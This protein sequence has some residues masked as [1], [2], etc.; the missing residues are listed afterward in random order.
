MSVMKKGARSKSIVNVYDAKTHLSEL[1]ERA[2]AGEEITIAKSGKPA[3]RL[4]SLARPANSRKPGWLKGR[5]W[6]SSDFDEPLSAE[7]LVGLP[8]AKT[9]R[10]TRAPR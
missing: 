4:V 7:F 5:I 1:V 2:A 10:K 9:A 6:T 3:A 8:Q